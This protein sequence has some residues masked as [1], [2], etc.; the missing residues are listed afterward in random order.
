MQTIDTMLD[1]LI[2]NAP[3]TPQVILQA[4][5]SQPPKVTLGPNKKCLLAEKWVLHACVPPY[6]AAQVHTP[7]EP[8]HLSWTDWVSRTQ[9][10]T[11]SVWQS[12]LCRTSL[13]TTSPH[14][15][16]ACGGG[17]GV[18]QYASTQPSFTSATHYACN[19]RS[20]S[21][22]CGVSTTVLFIPHPTPFLGYGFLSV[23]CSMKTN[24][25]VM[26]T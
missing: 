7:T 10:N 9:H 4:K 20:V 14:S 8:A 26:F 18:N 16:A 5:P 2:L 3:L 24:T 22:P 23:L 1:D 17:G 12:T 25:L 15:G 13:T 19:S 6:L 11:S 21:S